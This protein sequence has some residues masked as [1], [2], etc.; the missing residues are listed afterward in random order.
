MMN[1]V[2]AP[3]SFKESLSAAQAALAIAAGMRSALPEARYQCLPMADGGEGTAQT[4]LDALGGKWRE[5]VV[6]DPLR[7]VI[8]AR[9]ALLDDGCAVIETAATAGLNLLDDHE[10]D[11]RYSDT[12]G[13]GE[14]MLDAMNQG[15]RSLIIALGGSAT[16][17]A[18]VGMLSALG[19]RFY[20][21]DNQPLAPGGAALANLARIDPSGQHHALRDT[22]ITVA[23]DVDNPLTGERGASVVFAR[24]K[25]AHDAHILQLDQAL[26]HFAQI[27]ADTLG[28]DE[29][30]H[31]GA[32]AAGGLGFALR[33]YLRAELLSGVA[34]VAQV[35]GL[36]HAIAQADL[37]I[38]G[39]GRM[40][41]QTAA[42]K[43]PQGVLNIAHRYDV[44]VIALCGVLDV[45][46]QALD[47]AG[48]TA[49]L[50]I[51]AQ[52]SDHKTLL[53][54]GANNLQRTAK[55]VAHL[56]RLKT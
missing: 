56:L 31:A 54:Q 2:I 12:Y 39:E 1:I 44:P 29:R 32:G 55:Q 13:V 40:D 10:R 3:D 6:H 7:R 51:I 33:T 34:L 23:C 45:D 53:A 36:E 46:D 17:D 47:D 21:A 11:P 5:V 28:V 18:G 15:C 49:I 50:P 4:L 37:V 41:G 22:S 43:V 26:S 20:D 19:W 8:C 9:Y 52:V 24:Q 14:L 30:A 48:Y 27:S 35:V 25:G 16:N 38:T 42:G